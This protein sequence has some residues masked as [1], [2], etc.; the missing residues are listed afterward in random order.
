MSKLIALD[1]GHYVGTPGKRCMKALDPD[2]TREWTLNGRMAGHVERMLAPYDCRVMRVDDRTGKDHVT[3]AER[4]AAANGERADWYHS[5]HHNAG[6]NGGPGGGIAVYAAV[7]AG[8]AARQMQREI[9][10]ATVRRTGLRGNRADPMPLADFAVLR[11]TAM[12][13]TLGEYGFMDSSTDV[14]Q[15][16]TDGFSRLCAAGIAEALVKV[17]DL[18]L[19]EDM[20]MGQCAE[21]GKQVE[22]LER[23][24]ADLERVAALRYR[25]L[26]EVPDWAQAAVRDAVGRGIVK[27]DDGGG[28]GAG[29]AFATPLSWQGLRDI[30]MAYRRERTGASE[31]S[32]QP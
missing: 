8:A 13:A 6:V 2:E 14:P 22:G 3:L 18:K 32:G 20:D 23:R 7:A 21:T 31:R 15:I 1:A 19:R 17:A 16:I 10:A 26:A 4:I 24:V 25:T 12:P 11:G 27:A 30:E 28:D 29:A 9:Y 5:I